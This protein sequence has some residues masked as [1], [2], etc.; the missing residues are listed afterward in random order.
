MAATPLTVADGFLTEVAS[1]LAAAAGDRSG[2]ALAERVCSWTHAALAYQHDATTVRTTAA[3]AVAGGRGVCQ[4]YAHVMLAL[5]RAA[6][7]PS[8]YVSGHLVGGRLP[9]VGGGHRGPEDGGR[10][11]PHPRPAGAVGLRDG[12][13]RPRLHRRGAPTSGRFHGDSPGV[14]TARKSLSL[15]EGA[16]P[17]AVLTYAREPA[18]PSHGTGIVER[19]TG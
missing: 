11:R 6:G 12:G 7:L 15:V 10:V 4:D 17:E 14:L 2:V 13:C 8:R 3:K 16:A 9:R 19:S 5:C 1:E 18:K